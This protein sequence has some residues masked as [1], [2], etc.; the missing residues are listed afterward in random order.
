[1]IITVSNL[2]VIASGIVLSI[3]MLIVRYCAVW[4]T[5]KNNSLQKEWKML[6]V[7]LTRGLATAVLATLPAQYGLLYAN[8]FVDIT[9]IVIVVTALMAIVGSTL[10]SRKKPFT[11]YR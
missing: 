7:I 10:I 2:T 4:L 6:T 8:I 9:V 5:T 11:T 1:M 3:I